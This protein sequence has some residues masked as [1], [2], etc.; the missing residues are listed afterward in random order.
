MTD[1][2]IIDKIK[3]CF[4]LSGS[5]EAHEAAAALAK[6][7]QLM[8]LYGIRQVD[9]DMSRV[10]QHYR[11]IERDRPKDYEIMLSNIIGGAFGCKCIYDQQ[12]VK[13]KFKTCVNFIGLEP[14]AEIAAYAYAICYRRLKQSRNVY[15]ASL[16][17]YKKTGKARAAYSFSIGWVNAVF[18]QIQR[19][20]PEQ[21]IPAIV[22]DYFQDK[23][24][25]VTTEDRNIKAKPDQHM[26]KG[27]IEGKKV[28]LHP[29]MK[30]NPGNQT[31]IQ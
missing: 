18:A 15:L 20:I 8:V 10:Q 11:T 14:N 12:P 22:E 7:R 29:G 4:A 27:I 28:E 16:K 2:N 24:P 9:I 21:N 17:R 25:S 6:A 31:L 30:S 26:M 13:G 23:Y 1:P 5:M 19:L 3:K